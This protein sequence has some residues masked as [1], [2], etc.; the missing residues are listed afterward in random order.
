MFNR[1]NLEKIND[2]VFVTPGEIIRVG[3]QEVDFVKNQALNNT[4]GRARICMHGNSDV[5]LHEMLIAIRQDSYIGPHRHHNK[6]ESLHV[7]EGAATVVIFNND[8][9][10][11][12]SIKLSNSGTFYYR[13]NTAYYH[14][15]ILHTPILVLHEVTQGPFNLSDS[16]FAPFAPQ[17]KEKGSLEYM[18]NLAA[19]ILNS[20]AN[21]R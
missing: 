2:E 21:I 3:Q 1:L 18:N 5:K 7:I 20:H 19:T 6:A 4:R 8:G 11:M 9:S 12:N 13:L 10:I 15:L 16:D 14:T 17:E